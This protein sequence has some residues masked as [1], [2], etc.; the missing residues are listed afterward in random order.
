MTVNTLLRSA[1][2]GIGPEPTEGGL[3]RTARIGA[4]TVSIPADIVFPPSPVG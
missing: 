1:Q 2:Q 4:T 3:V